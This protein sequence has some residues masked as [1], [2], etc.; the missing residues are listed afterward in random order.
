MRTSF[1]TS[2]SLL[3]LATAQNLWNIKIGARWKHIPCREKYF[4]NEPC[5]DPEKHCFHPYRWNKREEDSANNDSP[6]SI[7]AT[8]TFVD[9][10]SC[11]PLAG[12]DEDTYQQ[13]LAVTQVC[14]IPS[15]MK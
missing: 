13:C 3:G 14:N 6:D 8:L 5:F 1:L 7:N 12:N 11:E 2:L 10:F 9:A 15:D 4:P